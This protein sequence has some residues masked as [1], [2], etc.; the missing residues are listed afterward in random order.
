MSAQGISLIFYY[1]VQ[2]T[3][4]LAD[5]QRHVPL[6]HSVVLQIH[7]QYEHWTEN[8][9]RDERVVVQG[10]LQVY[11]NK[12]VGTNRSAVPKLLQTGSA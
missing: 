4:S 7:T 10:I 9:E 3:W 2:K 1:L 11:P 8:E 6:A 5:L 12:N